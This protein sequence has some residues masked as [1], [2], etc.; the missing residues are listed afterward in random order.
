M[1]HSSVVVT[2]SSSGIGHGIAERFGQTGWSVVGLDVQSPPNPSPYVAETILGDVRERVTHEAA[3]TAAEQL[4]PLSAWINCAGIDE[5]Q[6]IHLATRDHVERVID[7]N[8][9]GVFWGCAV[10]VGSM[11]GRGGSIV[12]ISSVQAVRGNEGYPAY[13]ASKGGILGLTTQIAAEYA[14][15]AIRCN[16]ILPGVIATE[17]NQ[18]LLDAASDPEHLE[19]SWRALTPIG[20]FGTPD[21]V[22][23]LALFLCEDRGSFMT[24]SALP[25]DG[26]QLVMPPNW[27]FTREDQR[28]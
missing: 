10:A 16:A 26:G 3:A 6:S 20:R 11:L 7:V 9:L 21:D 19:R 1:A 5:N 17:M 15:K 23:E 4:A 12:N 25:V 2:G 22:A 18:Q 13:A 14:T 27:V 8:L 24:G 28:D